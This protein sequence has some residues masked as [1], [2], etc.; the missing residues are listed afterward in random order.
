MRISVVAPIYNEK[1]NIKRFIEKVEE[2][3]KKGFESYE[4]VMID[5]GR[6]DGRHEI[7][8]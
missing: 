1:D 5:V 4:I 7:L 6:S 2:A 3:E 8:D